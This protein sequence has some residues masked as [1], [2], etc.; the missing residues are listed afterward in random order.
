MD[1]PQSSQGADMRMF[2]A[3]TTI[4]VSSGLS[5]LA[6]QAA[7]TGTNGRGWGSGQGSGSFQMTAADKSCRISFPGIIDDRAGTRVPATNVTIT[8]SPTAGKVKV[9]AGRGLIY[10]PNKGFTGTDTFCTS[11]TTP[12]APGVTLSGCITVA[13]N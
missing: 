2:V 7:C 12:K 1:R 11:N 8:R 3:M 6:A 13:V 4:V 10:T 5:L 9:A